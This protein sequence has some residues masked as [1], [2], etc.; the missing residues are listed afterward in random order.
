MI[1]L[2][3]ILIFSTVCIAHSYLFFPIILTILA[4]GKQQNN[5][6]Y[7]YEDN[8]PFVSIILA[9]YNEEA[10][11][12]EKL[13]TTFATRYPL[14]KLEFLIGSDASTD[15]TNQLIEDWQKKYPQIKFSLFSGRTGKA[16]IVNKLSQ[17]AKGDIFILTD[18]N[19]FFEPDTIYQLVKHYKNEEIVQV[20]ANI[21][22]PI[23]KKEGI[24][25]QEKSY[26]SRE[27]L[28]KYQEG[29]I[30]GTM[31]GAFGGCYSIRSAAFTQ[32][33]PTFLM[34][35]F[36]ISMNALAKGGK[37]INELKALCYEDV[38]NKI[39]E[40]F[41]RK[42]RISAGNFQNLN[43]FRKLLLRYDGLSFCFW[44]HKVLRWYG[45][46]FILSA[47]IANI[48][49]ALT[50]N[51]YQLS[52]LVQVSILMVPLLDLLLRNRNVNIKI[53]RFITHFYLMNLALLLGWVRY[54]RG[55][56]ASVWT[57]T[58]RNQ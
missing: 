10:V 49:L 25:F 6:V 32:V 39:R 58:Q 17:D 43:H 9:V 57:P 33:P 14:E 8:L 46:F 44:S 18:A 16:G 47:L 5:L 45:P 26:L 24:S 51:F 12:I 19:V 21:L 41:R 38:S 1:I 31:I 3:F 28:I 20:G 36:Y 50:S 27:N 22:N 4:K 56:K 48:F 53:F 15:K 55:I 2:K 34:E 11:I 13:R 23:H 35:D 42:T 37:S 30:W 40:E 29:V 52:L 7:H 54:R